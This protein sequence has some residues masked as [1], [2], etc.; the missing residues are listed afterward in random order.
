[1]A[2]AVTA[3]EAAALADSKDGDWYLVDKF[4]T[5]T[6]AHTHEANLGPYFCKR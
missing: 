3:A 6:Y 4:F 5:W 1:M 2:R